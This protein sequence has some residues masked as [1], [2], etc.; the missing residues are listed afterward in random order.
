MILNDFLF[1]SILHYELTFYSVQESACRQIHNAHVI[2]ESNNIVCTPTSTYHHKLLCIIDVLCT[3]ATA[4]NYTYIFSRITISSISSSHIQLFSSPKTYY[5]FACLAYS[6]VHFRFT[7]MCLL[8]TAQHTHQILL[9]F[10]WRK[11][12][13]EKT[14]EQKCYILAYFHFLVT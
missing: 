4:Y 14:R 11:Q 2:Q 13:R 3:T 10:R 1:L 12:V 8:L 5:F 9:C 7:L 6:S